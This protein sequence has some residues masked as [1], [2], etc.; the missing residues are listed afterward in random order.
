[1][2][3]DSDWLNFESTPSG[4]NG[5]HHKQQP[6]QN[7]QNQ[8]WDEPNWRVHPIAEATQSIEVT[9]GSRQLENGGV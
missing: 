7:A 9:C 1:M 3:A 2:A 8:T 4:K 6:H 5:D